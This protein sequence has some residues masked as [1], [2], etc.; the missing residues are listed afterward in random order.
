[1]TTVATALA[2]SLSETGE[3]KVLYVDVN[4][5]QGA[6]VHPFQEGRAVARIQDA[7]VP[8]QRETAMV[9][10]QLYAVSLGGQTGGRVG[11]IPRTLSE[12]VPKIRASDYD[13]IIFDLPPISQTSVT[14][15]VAGLLDLNVLVLESE[16][17]LQGRAEQAVRLLS[18]SRS[19][20]VA[21]LNKH[22]RY[23]PTKLDADL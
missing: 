9:N 15:R 19:D 22:R 10:D 12:L 17:T 5:A 13:Y 6:S 3:G 11:V 20:V 7:L 8:E 2:A 21:V 23:L 16:K 18:E 14:A 4:P 1:V